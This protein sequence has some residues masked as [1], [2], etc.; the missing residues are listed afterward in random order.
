[1]ARFTSGSPAK[2]RDL[3]PTSDALLGARIGPD[4]ATPPARLM[5]PDQPEP[6][7]TASS[8]ELTRGLD[9]YEDEDTVPGD[10]LDELFRPAK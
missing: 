7:W 2:K 4:D 9:I 1:M 5:P 10:L 8:F 6:G 3:R